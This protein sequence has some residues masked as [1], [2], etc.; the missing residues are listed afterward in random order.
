M[1][2][3]VQFLYAFMLPNV[4]CNLKIRILYLC[5]I[6]MNLKRKEKKTNFNNRKF[7]AVDTGCMSNRK[8]LKTAQSKICES[9]VGRG[10][11][12]VA[13]KRSNNPLNYLILN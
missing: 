4:S 7:I 2:K 1:H 10:A 11:V 5:S 13:R 8:A 3:K 12:K 6:T 9:N